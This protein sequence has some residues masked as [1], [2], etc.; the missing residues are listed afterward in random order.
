MAQL[1]ADDS[2]DG[3]DGDADCGPGDPVAGGFTDADR[4]DQTGCGLDSVAYREQPASQRRNREALPDQADVDA[5]GDRDC[6][7]PDDNAVQRR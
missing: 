1:L 2:N 3:Y 7:D 5:A 4:L 6:E